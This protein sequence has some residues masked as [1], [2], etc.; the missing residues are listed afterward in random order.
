MKNELNEIINECV[1]LSENLYLGTDKDEVDKEFQ[2]LKN[3]HEFALSKTEYK[4]EEL[5]PVYTS[6]LNSFNADFFSLY[7]DLT[8]TEMLKTKCYQAGDNSILNFVDLPNIEELSTDTTHRIK[9]NLQKDN[10]YLYLYKNSE[11]NICFRTFSSSPFSTIDNF[12]KTV[13]KLNNFILNLNNQSYD[14]TWF[15]SIINDKLINYKN[16]LF[17]FYYNFKK[18][19][20]IF[21]HLG[22]DTVEDIAEYIINRINEKYPDAIMVYQLSLEKVCVFFQS[23]VQD[24]R[25]IF[26]YNEIPIPYVMKK[27]L[28]KGSSKFEK[29]FEYIAED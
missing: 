26:E 11:T 1:R 4:S 21:S 28:V 7:S 13:D 15:N 25:I 2:K 23:E 24:K 19:Y 27:V 29:L 22:I 16:D 6:F 12:N 9:L 17:L 5:K 18:L 10:I 20:G 14:Y 3:R 8:I